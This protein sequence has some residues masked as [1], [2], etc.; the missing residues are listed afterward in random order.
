MEITGKYNSATIFTDTIDEAALSQLYNM[1]N[2]PCFQDSRIAIMPDVHM[3]KGSVV[4]FT[5]SS[6]RYINPNV[7]G[8]DIGCG[9]TALN[10]GQVHINLE[11]FDN[12]VHSAIPAGSDIHSTINTQRAAAVPELDKLIRKVAPT[13]HQR[14]LLSIGSLGG[15]NHFIELDKDD[16]ANIWLIIHSG[17]RNLGLQVC[18]FHQQKAKQALKEEFKGAGAYHGME[19]LTHENG[20]NEYLSDMRIAQAYAELNRLTIAQILTEGY[21]SQKLSHCRQ[22][23]SVHNYFNFADNIVRKGAISAH[24]GESVI[25]PL[26]MRDG[27]IIG[28]G[29]GN[30]E[31]NF[32]APHGAG[33]LLKRGEAKTLISLAEY[34]EAMQGIYSTC[35]SERTI[36]ES[37]MAYKD[38][39]ELQQLITDCVDIETIIQP[40]YNF[41]A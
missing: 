10:L 6:N 24:K 26:N 2:I 3:G 5:M 41:K 13:E 8:V 18:R 35:V 17:S 31:W 23:T 29:K 39:N 21:L 16:H 30:P 34:K 37:P 1:L 9:I 7:I 4:G 36:D 20:G 12:F 27:C 11:Q 19:Y 15:G 38:T 14:I 28:T 40:I 33:R 32:S 25:I 22:I